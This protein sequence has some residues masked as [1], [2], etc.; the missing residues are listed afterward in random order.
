ME[1]NFG[2]VKNSTQK[3]N[4]YAFG[5]AID[6]DWEPA[7]LALFGQSGTCPP[8]NRA[9]G[10]EGGGIAQK[11]ARALVLHVYTWVL[12]SIAFVLRLRM[13]VIM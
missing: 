7:A 1:E 2:E 8:F 5:S 10:Q 11:G 13:L 9:F 4:L 12:V 3:K 6:S